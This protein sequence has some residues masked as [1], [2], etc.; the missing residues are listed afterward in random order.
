MFF[1][2]FTPDQIRHEMIKQFPHRKKVEEFVEVARRVDSTM[3][4]SALAS[5][6]HIANRMPELTSG[7]VS[8]RD[9]ADEMHVPYTTFISQV[10]YLA[11]ASP[12]SGRGLNLLDKRLHPTNKRQR[13]VMVTDHGTQ[14]MGKLSA[15]F[16]ADRNEPHKTGTVVMAKPAKQAGTNRK[17]KP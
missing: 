3:S 6:V 1:F 2:F 14:L 11:T 9:I 13:Q 8:L 10:D 15:V 16:A 12:P 17:K 7:E 5:F 4:V